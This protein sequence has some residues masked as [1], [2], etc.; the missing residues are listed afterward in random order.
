MD[1]FRYLGKPANQPTDSVDLIAWTG[2]PITVRLDCSEFSSLCPVTNQPDYGTLVIEYVPD[3]CLAE[4]KSLKLY[5]WKYRDQKG[6]N[7]V[8]VD[9]IAGDLYRQIKPRWLQVVGTFNPRGGIR[10]TAT[11]RRGSEEYKPS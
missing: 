2:E 7:E 10:V 4:T 8:L 6:F 3:K 5:L 9:A 1:E 11:A